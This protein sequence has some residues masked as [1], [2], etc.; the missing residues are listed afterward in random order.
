[1]DREKFNKGASLMGRIGIGELILVLVLALV[2]FGPSKLPDIGKA[3]GK[4]LREFKNAT[5]GLNS[6]DEVAPTKSEE[7]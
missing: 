2:I 1:M 4:G 3:L 5:K 7:K 6:D